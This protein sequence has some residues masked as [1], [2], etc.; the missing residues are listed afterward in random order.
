MV[1]KGQSVIIYAFFL[2]LIV[3]IIVASFTF[4]FWIFGRGQLKEIEFRN[5]IFIAKNA[6]KAGKIYLEGSL[7]YSVYQ[8]MYDNGRRGGLPSEKSSS[9][10]LPER[11]EVINYLKNEVQRNLDKYT[12][13][14]GTQK[15]FFEKTVRIPK[16]DVKVNDLNGMVNISIDGENGENIVLSYIKFEEDEYITFELSPKIEKTYPIRY[17]ELY[18]KA[19]KKYNEIKNGNCANGEEEK[20][21]IIIKVE[22]K[23]NK[24]IINVTDTSIRVPVFD[25]KEN[26]VVFNYISFIVTK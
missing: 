20:D 1:K 26:K 9:N 14:E 6:I 4:G 25:K 3:V 18:E 12:G 11:Q 10:K 13:T 8:A 16:V 23:D 5:D 21:S 24:C 15:S 17:F 2:A 22:K 19:D 7:D